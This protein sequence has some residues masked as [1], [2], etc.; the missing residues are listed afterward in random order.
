MMVDVRFDLVAVAEALILI[1]WPRLWFYGPEK[2]SVQLRREQLLQPSAHHISAPEVG[3]FCIFTHVQ[4]FF[5][6]IL[7]WTRVCCIHQSAASTG[8]I[9]ASVSV[10][11]QESCEM[12]TTNPRG[13]L[14][15]RRTVFITSLYPSGDGGFRRSTAARGRVNTQQTHPSFQS[16]FSLRACVRVC[17]CV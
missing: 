12:A 2:P 6:W 3:Y 1:C 10:E 15:D 7:F 14:Q 16:C 4:V 9:L 13:L 17:A 11:L 5:S 8:F